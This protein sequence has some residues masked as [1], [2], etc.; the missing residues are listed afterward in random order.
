MAKILAHSLVAACCS[1]IDT[2]LASLYTPTSLPWNTRIHLK[3]QRKSPSQSHLDIALSPRVAGIEHAVIHALLC[4]TEYGVLMTDHE[5]N[6]LLCNPRFGE[7]FDIDPEMVVHATRDVVRS[8]ALQKVKQPDSFLQVLERAYADPQL[9]FEDE[10]LVRS[11]PRRVLGR[12]T[13]P[14]LDSDGRNIGRVWTFKDITATRR[15]ERKVR[16]YSAQL[17]RQV[18]K[19]T[20]DLRLAYENLQ[21]LHSKMVEAAK[22]GVVGMLGA[23]I[24]HDIRNIMTPLKMEISL[25]GDG[26]ATEDALAHMDRLSALTHRLLSLGKPEK[27]NLGPVSVK[28]VLLRVIPLVRAQAQVNGIDIVEQLHTELPMIIADFGR[29]EHL[30][31]NLLLNGL[32]AMASQ[33]GTLTVAACKRDGGVRIDISDTGIG[34]SEEHL[35]CIFEPFYTTRA[36]G[37]GL[38]LFS[39]RNIVEDHGGE[40]TVS[41]EAGSG[42]CF[43]VWLPSAHPGENAKLREEES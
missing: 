39:A 41:S 20:K 1:D 10:I 26:S 3:T 29:I 25:L 8:L 11:K 13:G 43:K 15:L 22:I 14:V 23:S 12:Y 32:N 4:S 34:I 21:A 6:D 27:L 24:A 9:E 33:G 40:I 28:D 42:T 2:R 31:V 37:I 38:G 18:R 36:N 35:P 7:L 5:G 17:E 16:S 30:F 19:Q